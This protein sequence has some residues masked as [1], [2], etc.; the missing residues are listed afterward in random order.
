MQKHTQQQETLVHFISILNI[1]RYATQVYTQ[2]INEVMYALHKAKQDMNILLNIADVLTQ[3]LRYLQMY[4]YA[5][6]IFGHLRNCL[7]YMKQVATHTMDY[8]DTVTSNILSPDI[9]S[10]NYLL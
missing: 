9:L 5:C 6:S 1:T 4:T 8:V 10:H 2:K 3:C 7:T